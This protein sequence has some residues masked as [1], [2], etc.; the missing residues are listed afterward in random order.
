MHWRWDNRQ[1]VFSGAGVTA[2]IALFYF[3]RHYF[4]P[5]SNP[6]TSVAVSAGGDAVV[7]TGSKIQQ[8]VNSPTVVHS[9][10][11]INLSLPTPPA[12]APARARYE[13]WRELINEL[14][15][16]FGQIGF[17]FLPIN[18]ITPGVEDNGADFPVATSYPP[19][20]R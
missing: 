14:H 6:A 4:L 17:A 1:W 10:P 19:S 9:S 2:F 11:T 16:S 12:E 5:A 3:F 7:T 18:V 13:E 8:T 15:K 20:N